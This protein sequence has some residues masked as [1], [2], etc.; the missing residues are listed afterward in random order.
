MGGQSLVEL[1]QLFIDMAT[2]VESQGEMLD[3]I[4]YS[5]GQVREKERDRETNSR[6]GPLR[7]AC[8]LFET[9]CNM[10]LTVADVRVRMV[11]LQVVKIK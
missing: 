5:V 3:Q 1:H 8:T 10:A 2:L 11:Q 4:E 7:T 9:M 6:M